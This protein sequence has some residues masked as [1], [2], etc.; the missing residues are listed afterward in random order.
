MRMRKKKRAGERI[1]ACGEYM[2]IGDMLEGGKPVCLEIGC[3][4]GEFICET[5]RLRPDENFIAVERISDVMVSAVEKAQ[6]MDLPNA[7]FI[8]ADAIELAYILPHGIIRELYLNFSDP[9]PKRYQHNKR[10]TSPVFLEIYKKIMEPGGALA[11]KT[12]N[13]DLFGYSL[14]TLPR[15][16]FKI[17]RETRDLYGSEFLC[18]NIQTEYEKKFVDRGNKIYYFLSVKE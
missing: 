8:V 10:L 7:R 12:D 6:S 11:L 1:R 18:G 2:R 9:W 17:T 13:A 5:A 4:K 16:G 15:H 3:G 14:M